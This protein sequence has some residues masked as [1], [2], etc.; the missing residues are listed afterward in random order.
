MANQILKN[1]YQIQRQL[2]NNAGRQTLLALD[3]TTQNLVVIK[4]LIFNG[5]ITWEHF[6]LFEKEAKTL[7][8]LS[9]PAIPR[10]LDYF[11]VET[12]FGKGFALVQSYLNA[13]SLEEHIKQG[14][15]FS[16]V[17]LKAIAK[18]VLEI[19]SYIHNRYPALIHRDIKP[20]NILLS[21]RTAHSVGEVYLVDFGS[22]NNIL[23]SGHSMTIV[24]TYGY[25]P[26]EQFLGKKP[27]AASDLYGLGATLIYLATGENPGS[28]ANEEF[29]ICFE[30]YV[31]FFPSFTDW[32]QY[33]IEPSLKKRFQSAHEALKALEKP[34][35]TKNVSSG[36][37]A[38]LTTKPAGS[39]VILTK[40]N[41]YFQAIISPQ[42]FSMRVIPMIGMAIFWHGFLVI[43]YFIAL[44]TWFSG[45]WFFAVLTLVHLVM[46]MWLVLVILFAI[47]GETSLQIDHQHISLKYQLFGLNYYQLRSASR[48]DI[49]KIEK[50]N[51]SYIKN[52]DGDIVEV[53]PKINLWV[54]TKKVILGGDDLLSDPELDWLA[55]ELSDWLDLSLS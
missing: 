8:N 55:Y 14:C 41:N 21:N 7:K 37:I 10:Y 27:I 23:D 39:R 42:G 53:K 47:L 13:I 11:E 15:T 33:M 46:G 2:G 43:W 31:N 48:Q 12:N 6:K 38:I 3:T 44:S 28:L 50:I 20:A 45:G 34:K 35:L 4:L 29:R 5:E 32:L 25:M 30:D 52:Y 24:G 22:V 16:E 18:G 19:L 54:G 40:E 36:N 17:D 49:S 26:P 51:T 9:H 1:R